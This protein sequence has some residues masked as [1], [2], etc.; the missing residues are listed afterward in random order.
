[1]YDVGHVRCYRQLVAGES[2]KLGLGRVECIPDDVEVSVRDLGGSVFR[3]EVVSISEESLDIN[4]FLMEAKVEVD[5][6]L[7]P[8]MEVVSGDGTYCML[9]V[10]SGA[11]REG[12]GVE[13]IGGGR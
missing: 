9:V 5:F 11:I 1:M 6:I 4:F 10:G 12:E 8:V 2:V 13:R 7:E 3:E